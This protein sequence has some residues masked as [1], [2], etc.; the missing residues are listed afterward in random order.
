MITGMD[1]W[2]QLAAKQLIAIASCGISYR[3]PRHSSPSAG[4]SLREGAGTE[5]QPFN[6]SASNSAGIVQTFLAK[7]ISL[8]CGDRL[9][10]LSRQLGL[11]FS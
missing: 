5:S 7:S 6:V 10:L 2:N 8:G 3:K 9:R 4:T 11:G 1:N